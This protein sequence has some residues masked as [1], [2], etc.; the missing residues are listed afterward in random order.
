MLLSYLQ[1]FYAAFSNYSQIFIFRNNN[2]SMHQ[3]IGNYLQLGDLWSL[4]T[5]VSVAQLTSTWDP[6]TTSGK[7]GGIPLPL[8]KSSASYLASS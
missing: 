8:V 6:S 4:P 2:S 3:I 7:M 1:E 5:N